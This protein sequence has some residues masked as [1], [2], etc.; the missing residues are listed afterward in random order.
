MPCAGRLQGSS[1]SWWPAPPRGALY[2]GTLATLAACGSR[3]CRWH[4]HP[5][6]GRHPRASVPALPRYDT[7]P[8]ALSPAAPRGGAS[9][10]SG[11]TA[12]LLSGTGR[13]RPDCRSSADS[14]RRIPATR[15]M[16]EHR[17]IVGSVASAPSPSPVSIAVQFVLTGIVWGSSFLFIAIALTGMTP[18]QVAGGRLLFGAL[19]LVPSSR[20]GGSACPATG[21]SGPTCACCLQLLRRAVPAVR[22]GRAARVVG[23]GE[24]L[25]R[26]HA[27]HDRDH[28]VGGVPR[29]APRA[30]SAARRRRGYRRVS[31]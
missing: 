17:P 22:V 13:T 11:S 9:P 1:S 24:H 5:G 16:S 18:A 21:A 6:P 7:R 19:A 26:H 27:D 15:S 20:S 2:A 30:R 12:A 8:A 14:G 29:R 4:R 31:S 10:P 3:P 25:Q 28:G 23:T